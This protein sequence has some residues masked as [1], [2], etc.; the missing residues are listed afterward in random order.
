VLH[1]NATRRAYAAQWLTRHGVRFP[2]LALAAGYAR[3]FCVPRGGFTRAVWAGIV[4]DA[5]EEVAGL[6]SL[7]D[8]AALPE[9]Q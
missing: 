9:G 7:L 2:Q 1:A 6:E 8:P 3:S 4:R 5:G